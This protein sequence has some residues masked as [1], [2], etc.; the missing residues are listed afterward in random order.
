[1]CRNWIRIEDALDEMPVKPLAEG[2]PKDALF[3]W[4][5][6]REPAVTCLA[7]LPRHQ[8]KVEVILPKRDQ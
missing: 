2:A 3:F 4:P 7:R 8:Q 6:H 5:K 1:M